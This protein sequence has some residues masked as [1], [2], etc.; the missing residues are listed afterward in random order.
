M[1][2]N[3]LCRSQSCSQS[4]RCCSPSR[5]VANPNLVAN[6]RDANFY[7][8]P[9][10]FISTHLQL[11]F[12]AEYFRFDASP[13]F[14]PCRVLSSRTRHQ[15]LFPAEYFRLERATNF[16]SLPSTFVSNAPPTF[17]PCRVFSSRTRLQ[18]LFP[19][20]YLVQNYIRILFLARTSFDLKW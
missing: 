10:I 8:L 15:L 17:I 16:Y 18:L 2:V 20:E 3:G 4:P 7:S 6:H 1:G 12:P 14:I 11:L 9:S 19:A 13:T 5:C